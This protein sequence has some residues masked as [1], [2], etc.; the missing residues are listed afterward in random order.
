M[1]TSETVT[2]AEFQFQR[3]VLHVMEKKR[4]PRWRVLGEAI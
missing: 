3:L 4:H 1:P 2:E